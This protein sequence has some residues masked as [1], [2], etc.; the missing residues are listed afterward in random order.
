MDAVVG[1]LGAIVIAHWSIGLARTAGRS[2]LDAH[3][4]SRI[5]KVVRERLMNADAGT[6]ISDLHVWRLGPGYHGLIA[7]LTTSSPQPPAH[8][9]SL[10]ADLPSLGH[11][12]IEVNPP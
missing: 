11:V 6:L 7:T 4:D 2:L 3:D 9:R 12:T 1:I 8:Y 10:L 5:E